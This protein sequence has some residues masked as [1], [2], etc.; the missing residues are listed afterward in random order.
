MVKYVGERN[1]VVKNSLVSQT[2]GETGANPVLSRNG[3]GILS[4]IEVGKPESDY[5]PSSLLSSSRGKSFGGFMKLAIALLSRSVR[6][7]SVL[8]ARPINHY[9]YHCCYGGVA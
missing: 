8:P 2:T 5:L 1:G 3:K 9:A 7:R 6:Y 4:T